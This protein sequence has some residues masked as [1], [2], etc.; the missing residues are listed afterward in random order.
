MTDIFSGFNEFFSMFN[1]L[2]IIIF[3]G[4]LIF[5]IIVIIV[6]YKLL[7]SNVDNTSKKSRE[8]LFD[9]EQNPYR[10]GAIIE[11]P[12]LVRCTYCGENIEPDIAYCPNCGAELKK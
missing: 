3:V 2:F 11:E 4:A 9:P 10:K 5:L 7:H 1:F 8:I 6:V 12:I